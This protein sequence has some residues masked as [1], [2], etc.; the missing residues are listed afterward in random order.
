MRETRFRR[1][2]VERRWSSFET[3]DV[4]FSLARDALAGREREPRLC[5]IVVSRRTFERWM[6][7]GVKTLPQP[8]TCRILEHL[9]GVAAQDLFAD[10]DSGKSLADE[11]VEADIGARKLR[12]DL[13]GALT[14]GHM[15][16]EGLDA[17]EERVA[18][19]GREM[20]FRADLDVQPELRQDF[21]E[22]LL[23]LDRRQSPSTTRRLTRIA[24]WMAGL[25]TLSLVRLGAYEHARAWAGTALAAADE[26]DDDAVRAWVLA[27]NAY[28]LFY[29]GDLAGAADE[30]RHAR[31]AT[32]GVGVGAAL[33]APLEA[34][35]YAARGD[36]EQAASALARAEDA[37]AGLTTEQL[38]DSALGYTE[39][40][41]RF[42]QGNAWTHLGV[43]ERA[44]EAQGRA[45]ELLPE[46]E[47]LDRALVRVDTAMCLQHVGRTA[48]AAD[49]LAT[50]IEE[51]PPSH[52]PGIVVTRAREVAGLLPD[53]RCAPQR[54]RDV[55]DIL[56]DLPL[57]A[58]GA[59]T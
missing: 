47:L 2:I 14:S 20:R 15:S 25:M 42:H 11:P 7:G 31:K 50:V 46:G 22:L 1:V 39:A 48:E 38:V 44:L 6:A 29:S 54:V 18:R 26:T 53:S 33:A 57:S 21:A 8:N 16:H 17:W 13:E 24:A 58:P 28:G 45:L 30:A 10:A 23:A 51:L 5:E 3:F 32:R 43:V 59:S 34:R 41:L 4:K 12:Q 55:R 52:R 56:A 19:H 40:Q 36:H 37:L 27:Q 35:A 9:L 49:A